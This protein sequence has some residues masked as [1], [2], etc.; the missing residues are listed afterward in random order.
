VIGVYLISPASTDAQRRL[1]RP[2]AVV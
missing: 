2:Q 1:P